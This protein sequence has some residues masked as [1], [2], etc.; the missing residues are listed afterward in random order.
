MASIV[1]KLRG[2]RIAR[3]YG[4]VKTRNKSDEEIDVRNLKLYDYI[5]IAGVCMQCEGYVKD[6]S[7]CGS[8]KHEESHFYNV[9]S[10]G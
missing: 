2:R 5:Y 7:I 6:D 4:H 1:D 8:C 3:W 10:E 9:G